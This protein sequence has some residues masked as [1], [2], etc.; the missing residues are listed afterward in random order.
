MVDGF[1]KARL[2]PIG[3]SMIDVRCPKCGES[4]Y[5]VNYS[6]RTAAYYPPIFKDGVN[7]NPDGNIETTV[8]YCLNCH[9]EFTYQTRYGRIWNGYDD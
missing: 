5:M 4:Y 3:G 8:C 6:T 2:M 1:S 9:H 7:V